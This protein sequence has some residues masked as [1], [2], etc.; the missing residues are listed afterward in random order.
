MIL[1]SCIQQAI[2]LFSKNVQS[3]KYVNYYMNNV[4]QIVPKISDES[5]KFEILKSFAELCI[6]YNGVGGDVT[7]TNIEILYNIDII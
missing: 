3:T 6:H 5:I 7:A 1:L 2:P 4:L